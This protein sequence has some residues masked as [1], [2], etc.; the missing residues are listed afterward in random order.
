MKDFPVCGQSC[1][2]SRFSA[3]F[4][5]LQKSCKRPCRKAFRASASQ[6]MDGVHRTPKCGAVPTPLHPDIQF[7]LLY[8]AGGENQSFSCLW[9]FLWSKPFFGLVPRP[10]KI[11][12]TPVLQGFP[13]F[14]FSARGWGIERSQSRRATNCATPGYLIVGD[15]R[16]R[17]AS[18]CGAQNFCAALRRALEILTAATRSAPCIRHRRR[19]PRSP[20]ALLPGYE[21]ICA[22]SGYSIKE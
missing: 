4:H 1:G 20:T 7:L 22:A 18:C 2:Q 21:I 10:S 11:P 15:F 13:G 12:Q 17:R 9:S 16:G 3:C 14:R 19:S 6:V 5:N 8:H